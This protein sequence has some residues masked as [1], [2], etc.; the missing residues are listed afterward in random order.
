MDLEKTKKMNELIGELKKHR[1]LGDDVVS[2]AE[3]LVLDNE[4]TLPR[5]ES[6]I[7]RLEK[8]FEYI[9]SENNKKIREELEFL[10][11]NML[12]LSEQLNALSEEVKR[13]ET[14][15]G[16]ETS[17]EQQITEKPQNSENQQE[18]KVNQ[19]VKPGKHPKQGG[20]SPEDV[21]VD[22]VFYFGNK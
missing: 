6:G 11:D 15:P 9:L 18:Q 8:R 22:K 4:D 19:E 3:E 13:V 7:K 12:K 5:D 2:R 20:Y 10:K 17:S 14:S 1:I 16:A 21:A